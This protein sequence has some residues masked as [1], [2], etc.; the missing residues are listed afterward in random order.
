MDPLLTSQ[1]SLKKLGWH[2]YNIFT[3]AEWEWRFAR[4]ILEETIS[5]I[6]LDSCQYYHVADIHIAL[7][8]EE[9]NSIGD[10]V[11]SSWYSDKIILN[12]TRALPH[13]G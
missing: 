1:C 8:I 3:R 7:Y 13:G 2:D 12:G 9:L 11:A 6:Q 5:N 10:L 4:L